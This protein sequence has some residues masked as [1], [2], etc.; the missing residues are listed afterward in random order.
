M[1]MLPRVAF[2]HCQIIL[3]DAVL[4]DGAVV[5]NGR[6]I[7][8]VSPRW[9]QIPAVDQILDLGGRYLAPGLIDLHIHG[10]NGVDV[11]D[12]TADHL[13]T[14]SRF[15]VKQ[16][17]TRY[18]PTT[19]P[20]DE[21][22]FVRVIEA[23]SHYRQRQPV[24]LAQVLGIHFEGPFVNPSR[25]GALRVEYIRDFSSATSADVFLDHALTT[26]IPIRMMTVAPEIQ[27]GL[28]LIRTLADHGYVVSIGHSQASFEVCE[29]ASAAG[30]R[31]V[32][33]F[34]NALAPLHHRQPG[35]FG[36]ALLNQ[37]VT[38]D[39]IADGHHVDWRVIELINRLKGSN[40]MALISDAIAPAGLGDGVYQVWGETIEVTNGRTRN[41]SGTIA[42][43][44]ISLWDAVC[45]LW[46]RGYRLSDLFKMAS[47]SPA[48][49]V[50]IDGLCGSIEKGKRADLICFDEAGAIHFVMVN[51]QMAYQAT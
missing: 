33:H 17:V 31:H 2:Q 29:A 22:S 46:R 3:P 8:H 26:Q 13:A 51:G 15:L 20:T 18:L 19:V 23:V 44:V 40:Q 39:V 43:S 50:G 6:G 25:C 24:N 36:W 11:L 38:L 35:V 14:L 9:D 48:R 34:P 45:N 16:G 42:G 5:T 21:S 7:E 49:V 28:A 32:T 1:P 47:L 30:A 12:A 10:S 4:T 27:G 41:A 37:N